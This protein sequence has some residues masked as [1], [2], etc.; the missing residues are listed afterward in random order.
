MWEKKCFTPMQGCSSYWASITMDYSRKKLNRWGMGL[1]AYYFGNPPLEFLGIS[2]TPGNSNQSKRLHPRNSTKFCYTPQNFSGLKSR[3]LGISHDFFLITSGNSMLLLIS[4]QKI[5]FC[6]N[7][8]N[9]R[10][11][12]PLFVSFFCNSPIQM[13]ELS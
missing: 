3:P 2:F 5:H 8:G 4:T 10:S 11:S 6:S 1:K 12:N 13:H 7:S 9:S